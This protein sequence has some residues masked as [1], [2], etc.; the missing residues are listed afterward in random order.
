MPKYLVLQDFFHHGNFTAKD[1][2][3]EAKDA[4][5][6]WLSHALTPYVETPAVE[7]TVEAKVEPVAEAPAE[8]VVAVEAPKKRRHREANEANG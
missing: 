8:A 5:V 3:I 1:S 7:V 2:V 6:K 4:E